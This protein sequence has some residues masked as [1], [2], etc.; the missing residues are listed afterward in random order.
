M[1]IIKQPSIKRRIHF[2]KNSEHPVWYFVKDLR[3]ADAIA[4]YQRGHK[5]PPHENSGW[6]DMPIEWA[7]ALEFGDANGE[8]YLQFIRNVK[9]VRHSNE[10]LAVDRFIGDNGWYEF[11]DIKNKE[12]W[13]NDFYEFQNHRQEELQKAN[14]NGMQTAL[15]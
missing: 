13:L 8:N 7:F 4:Y 1:D 10:E 11:A 3:D 6:F 12:K 2:F 14:R 9:G 15:F 5:I